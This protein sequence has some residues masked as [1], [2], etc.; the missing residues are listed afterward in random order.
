M[1]SLLGKSYS[2]LSTTAT[3]KSVFANYSIALIVR[4]TNELNNNQLDLDNTVIVTKNCARV[5]IQPH[6]LKSGV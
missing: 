6:K 2:V 3:R 4:T 1:Y 5:S